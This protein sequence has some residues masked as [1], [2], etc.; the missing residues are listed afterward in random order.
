MPG[1]TQVNKDFLKTIFTNEKRLLKKKEVNYVSVPHWEELSV[2]RLWAD[3]KDDGAFNAYFQEKY[4]DQKVPNWEYFFNIL[5]T[6]YLEY[7]K[8]IVDHARE[9]RYTVAGEDVKP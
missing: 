4:A 2:R 3:L 6:V 1:E 5:N 9:Q 7:L 8:S